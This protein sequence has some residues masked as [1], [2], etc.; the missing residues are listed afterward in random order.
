MVKTSSNVEIV[1]LSALPTE[2]SEI[3]FNLGLKWYEYPSQKSPF[4]NRF[5][6]TS[7]KFDNKHSKQTIEIKIV[8]ASSREMGLTDSAILTAMSLLTFSPKILVTIGICTGIQD[9]VNIG[10][11]II[12]KQSFHYQFGKIIQE[13][14]NN[15]ILLNQMKMSRSSTGL[16]QKLERFLRTEGIAKIDNIIRNRGVRRPFVPLQFS[17]DSIGSSDLVID[18]QLV[19]EQPKAQDRK[20]VAVDMESYS[21]LETAEQLGFQENA[22]VIKAVRDFVAN[23]EGDEKYTPLAILAATQTFFL[24]T[25]YLAE[26]TDFF[27]S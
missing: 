21:V 24:F 26:E 11:I 25:K 13:E 14:R 2:L 6:T 4:L 27:L 1:I 20:V 18:A 15:K 23:K 16:T 17:T 22:L 8:K 7:Q 5:Q 10:D 9:E 12:P 3:D 19:L